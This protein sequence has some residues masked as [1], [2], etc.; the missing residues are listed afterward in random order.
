MSVTVSAKLYVP[1]VVGVPFSVRPES[2]I[3]GGRLPD[4]TTAEYGDVPPDIVKA[5]L[6]NC[7]KRQYPGIAPM[8]IGFVPPEDVVLMFTVNDLVAE[9]KLFVAVMLNVKLP[10]A[11]GVPARLPTPSCG[12][13]NARPVGRVPL[14]SVYVVGDAAGERSHVWEYPAPNVPSGKVIVDGHDGGL[15]LN[16]AIT[17]YAC[18]LL[19]LTPAGLPMTAYACDL[20][21]FTPSGLRTT[22]Y[23][24]ALDTLTPVPVLIRRSA[25]QV[26][27][28]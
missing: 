1:T 28:R 17:A 23:A 6:N 25:T 22:A 12:L 18:D 7:P 16:A 20:L 26:D 19:T 2:D 21:T 27:S 3:P 5:V 9:P 10:R 4:A 24:R 11:V 14:A 8:M 15:E 13:D